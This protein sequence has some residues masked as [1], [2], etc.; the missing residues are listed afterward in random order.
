M[1][2]DVTIWYKSMKE[3]SGVAFPGQWMVG[4]VTIEALTCMAGDVT[5]MDAIK[6]F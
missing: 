5:C 1:V 4:D 3:C 6:F 2:G